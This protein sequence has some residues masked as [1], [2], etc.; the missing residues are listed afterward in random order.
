ME[1]VPPSFMED[2]ANQLDFE[3]FNMSEL[4]SSL[5]E[6]VPVNQSSMLC[7]DQ[8]GQNMLVDDNVINDT[9]Q[10]T[11]WFPPSFPQT[12]MEGA[13][14]SFMDDD[15]NH[16]DFQALED[17]FNMSELSWS[18]PEEVPVNQSS[19]SCNDQAGQNL[20]V[21]IN[22]TIQ[23]TTRFPPSFPQTMTAMRG[24]D[25]TSSS[26]INQNGPNC[27]QNPSSDQ[28]WTNQLPMSNQVPG[29]LPQPPMNQCS[30]QFPYQFNQVP[31]TPNLYDP[32]CSTMLPEPS[33]TLRSPQ[34]P[35]HNL[36]V[37]GDHNQGQ[38]DQASVIPH[39]DNMQQENLVPLNFGKSTR[40]QMDSLQVRGLQN[41]VARPNASNSGLDI[42]LQSQNRGLNTQQVRIL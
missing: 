21:N 9:I 20:L 38:V 15:V 11:T 27:P 29:M 28:Q 5:P 23:Q 35:P 42:S 25:G 3:T 24:L 41:R 16:L 2:D 10:Q 6:E 32:Q 39:I 4:P 7:N 33:Q 17:N 14:P 12:M 30:R 19:I 13:P 37:S 22:D 8:A 1:G 31:I 36:Q 34:F 26:W 40:S 18:P